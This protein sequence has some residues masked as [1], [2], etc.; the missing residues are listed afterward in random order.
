MKYGHSLSVE[1]YVC[2]CYETQGPL[3]DD[4]HH[5]TRKRSA[6]LDELTDAQLKF[7][8]TAKQEREKM[9]KRNAEEAKNKQQLKQNL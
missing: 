2:D 7:I 5:P 1:E 8:W 3:D 4:C 9:K 6:Y